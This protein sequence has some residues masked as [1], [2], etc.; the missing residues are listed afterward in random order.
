[1]VDQV[2]PPVYP[3]GSPP[4]GALGDSAPQA[5]A[6]DAPARANTPD[7]PPSDVS[8]IGLV[9]TYPEGARVDTGAAGVIGYLGTA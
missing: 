8:V 3:T 1:M 4:A 2:G 6:H 5:P 7:S 9:V